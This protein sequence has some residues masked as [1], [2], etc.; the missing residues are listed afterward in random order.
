MA[1]EGNRSV[2]PFQGLA[3]MA[4]NP[5]LRPLR[6]LRPGLCCFAASRLDQ[7]RMEHAKRQYGRAEAGLGKAER[8]LGSD[9]SLE[10]AEQ[11]SPG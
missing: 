3:L 9:A 6:G 11:Q 4:H 8:L 2:S 1:H 10:E 5:G 7:G